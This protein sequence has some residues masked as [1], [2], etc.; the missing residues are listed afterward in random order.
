MAQK[1]DTHRRNDNVDLLIFKVYTL[2][3]T[4]LREQKDKPHIEKKFAKYR[5]EKEFVFK[6]HTK[7]LKLNSKLN[8]PIKNAHRSEQTPHQR[9]STD[10]K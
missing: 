4:L 1:V 5:S 9:W 3:K 7:F 8:S 2:G 10:G 6:I